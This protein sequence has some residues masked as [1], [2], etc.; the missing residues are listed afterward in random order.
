MR[1]AVIA[2]PPPPLA[3][4]SAYFSSAL[5]GETRPERAWVFVVEEEAR[6]R[7]KPPHP[8]GQSFTWRVSIGIGGAFG[9]EYASRETLDPMDRNRAGLGG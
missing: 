6:E 3:I 9:A 2:G 5:L 4:W 1:S 7:C 8:K